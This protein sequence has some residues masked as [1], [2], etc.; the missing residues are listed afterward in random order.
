[1][2]CPF[3]QTECLKEECE[4]YEKEK[5]VCEPFPTSGFFTKVIGHKPYCYALNRF[6]PERKEI[7]KSKDWIG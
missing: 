4:A 5:S 3:F 2:K 1:M 7:N 6:L